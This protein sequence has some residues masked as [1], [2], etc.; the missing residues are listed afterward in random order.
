MARRRAILSAAAGVG[1]VVAV[2]AGGSTPAA[3]KTPAA[4][5]SAAAATASKAP[6]KAINAN[7][8]ACAGVQGVL[9]HLAADTA[10]WSPT[11]KPFDKAIATRIKLL[12]GE[13]DAQ[14]K[15]AESKR[16]D[17]AIHLSASAFSHVSTAM[18]STK[19]SA[20]AS[21]IHDSKQAYKVLKSVCS[22]R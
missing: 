14:A 15:Q 21:A 16:I 19:Q 4:T 5:T 8:R 11:L 6:S 20:V 2:L 18:L 7:V 3:P 22:L 17:A 13:L 10:H 1:L 12:A 9:G